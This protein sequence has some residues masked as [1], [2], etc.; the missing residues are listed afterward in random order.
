MGQAQ[1]K[2]NHLV[3]AYIP[4]VAA[5]GPRVVFALRLRTKKMWLASVKSWLTI[6]NHRNHSYHTT[7]TTPQRRGQRW[8]QRGRG[9][10]Q[11]QQQ[12]WNRAQTTTPVVWAFRYVLILFCCFFYYYVTDLFFFWAQCTTTE[13]MYGD[14]TDGPNDDA[15]RLGPQ[16]CFYNYVDFFFPY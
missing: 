10:Q 5:H 6:N 9:Q 8:G 15:S 2:S 3:G 7:I 13:T 11:Q 12:W 14:E 1:G 4:P 16:V